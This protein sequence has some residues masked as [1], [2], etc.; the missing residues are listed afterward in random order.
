[1]SRPGASLAETVTVL[2]LSGIMLAAVARYAGQLAALHRVQASAM[3]RARTLETARTVLEA[4]LRYLAPGRDLVGLSS[5]S[6]AGRFFRGMGRICGDGLRVHYRGI[7]APDPGKDSLLFTG[8][9]D[10]RPFALRG[11]SADL[12]VD[13]TPALRLAADTAPP[14]GVVLLFEH[15]SYHVGGGGLRYRIGRA[16]RQPLTGPLEPAGARFA[17]LHGTA[18]DTVGI[19]IAEGL[20]DGGRRLQAVPFLNAQRLRRP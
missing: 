12:C 2:A 1:M 5:D 8:G 7:R 20:R 10:P 4:E 15:G 19:V 11:L 14:H 17:P 3:E 6:L 16:G 13:G 9:R 18:A